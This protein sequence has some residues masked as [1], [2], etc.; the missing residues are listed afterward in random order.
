[1]SV[2][3]FERNAG[4][5]FFQFLDLGENIMEMLM[6]LLALVALLAA[7]EFAYRKYKVQPESK[8]DGDDDSTKDKTADTPAE[9]PRQ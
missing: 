6:P 5:A 1:M 8:D 9:G 2:L 4:V 3:A 7:A